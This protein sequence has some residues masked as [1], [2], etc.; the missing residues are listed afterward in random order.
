M[1]SVE[2]IYLIGDIHGRYDDLINFLS[3]KQL[4]DCYILC[5][6]DFGIGSF[7]P[8]IGE[9][10]F[11]KLNTRLKSKN[12]HFYTIRGNHDNPIYFDG[13]YQY[14]NL[15]LLEDYHFEVINDNR[16]LFV[17]GAVSI[18][19][20]IRQKTDIRFSRT[21]WWKD[22]KFIFDKS[23]IKECD[24]L[25]TH[26]I[27]SWQFKQLQLNNDF[28]SLLSIYDPTLLDEIDEEQ[29]KIGELIVSCGCKKSFHGHFHLSDCLEKHDVKS[30]I[31]DVFELY[32]LS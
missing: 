22:E 25:V 11:K 6:G 16:F 14:S 13:S 17:G 12:I 27:S 3:E 1:K 20:S 21:T 28:F 7:F 23:K 9:K 2:D 32:K 29:N 15:K 26:S 8:W 31:L 10:F 18:D 4:S 30:T 24:I 5:V 19:R